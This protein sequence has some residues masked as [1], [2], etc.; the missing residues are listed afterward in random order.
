M[1]RQPLTDES[2]TWFDL[3]TAESF[4]ED[5]W[6]NGN[7]H[8]SSATAS[9]W[10]HERLYRTKSKRWVLRHWSQW[11]GTAETWEEIDDAAAAAWL[12]RNDDTHPDVTEE[13]V[14]LEI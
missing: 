4:D 14:V 12:V 9:Q 8:I 5:T 13:I 10:E 3:D 6:W 11:Q 2:G 7:N 1:N